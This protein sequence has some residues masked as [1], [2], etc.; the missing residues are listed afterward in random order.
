MRLRVLTAAGRAFCAAGYDHVGLREVAAL[1]GTDPA[2]VVRLFG[3][4]EAL[5]TAVADDAFALEPPFDGPLDELGLR[6]ARHLTGK[7]EPAATEEFDEFR[8]LLHSAASPTAAPILSA[9]LHAGFVAPLARHLGGPDAERRAALATAC[10]LGFV[11]LRVA[12][13][14]ARLERGA[15][16]V[17]TRLGA[18]LQACLAP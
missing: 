3:S 5:F 12:L 9:A 15:N 10:V 2:I 16:A 11:T 13:G 8:F 1:A 18:V 7:S 6:I 4:K 17:I 14:S